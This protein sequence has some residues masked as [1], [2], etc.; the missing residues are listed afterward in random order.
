MCFSIGFVQQ[1]RR[2]DGEQGEEIETI[3]NN[4]G[5]ILG[6]QNIIL[7]QPSAKYLLASSSVAS[8][9]HL[10]VIQ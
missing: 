3:E 1:E 7:P 6:M 4:P 8:I 9:E 10:N 5:T 2:D